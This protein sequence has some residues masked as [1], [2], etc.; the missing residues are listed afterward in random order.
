MYIYINLLMVVS[1]IDAFWSMHTKQSVK[2]FVLHGSD[3]GL[4]V[5]PCIRAQSDIAVKMKSF[6]IL[7]KH[8]MWINIASALRF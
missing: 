5:L 3:H 6:G 7:L 1:R 2:R 8:R 4:H